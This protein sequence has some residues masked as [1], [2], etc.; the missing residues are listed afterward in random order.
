VVAAQG[1]PAASPS[2][3]VDPELAIVV[4][5]WDRLPEAVR[6]AIVAMVTAISK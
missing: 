5:A 1:Q 6:A 2:P 3:N 4:D